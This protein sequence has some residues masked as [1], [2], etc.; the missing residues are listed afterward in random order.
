MKR[1]GRLQLV[2]KFSLQVRLYFHSEMSVGVLTMRST[3]ILLRAEKMYA[4][5][6]LL[7]MFQAKLETNFV[8]FKKAQSL[9][10]RKKINL[11]SPTVLTLRFASLQLSPLLL[12]RFC[13]NVSNPINPIN[14]QLNLLIEPIFALAV[15][16]RRAYLLSDRSNREP[17]MCPKLPQVWTKSSK[18]HFCWAL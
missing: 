2:L 16:T 7:L 4:T 15:S 17:F 3:I 11:S 9:Q 18:I 5:K 6:L 1:T 14:A 12:T 13:K 10:A 8:W